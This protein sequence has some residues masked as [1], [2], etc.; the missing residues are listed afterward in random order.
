[1]ENQSQSSETSDHANMAIKKN[2]MKF[3]LWRGRIPVLTTTNKKAEK[4]S[5]KMAP[6]KQGAKQRCIITRSFYLVH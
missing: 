6:G 3:S 1:M 2:E 4:K 5:I